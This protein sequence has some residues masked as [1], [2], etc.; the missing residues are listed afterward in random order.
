ML[1]TAEI[2]VDF[3][4]QVEERVYTIIPLGERSQ[5][6]L[7]QITGELA[8]RK[9][10]S[11]KCRLQDCQRELRRQRD[12]CEALRL[13]LISVEEEGRSPNILYALAQHIEASIR[14]VRAEL[15]LLFLPACLRPLRQAYEHVRERD[16][17][18]AR[19]EDPREAHRLRVESLT[20]AVGA[21]DRARGLV[22]QQM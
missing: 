17:E 3:A 22:I 10:R 1:S 6:G 19:E 11:R 20:Q 2:N 15:D 9:R 8:E 7:P 4:H 21:I 12:L 18:A 16:R 14:L 13:A 5:L